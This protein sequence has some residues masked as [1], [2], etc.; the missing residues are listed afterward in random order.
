ML[1]A[2]PLD[3]K[4]LVTAMVLLLAMAWILGEAMLYRDN[5]LADHEPGPS[6]RDLE[7]RFTG[8]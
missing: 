6:I 3:R 2:L 4:A 7:L 1:H 8:G 5:A